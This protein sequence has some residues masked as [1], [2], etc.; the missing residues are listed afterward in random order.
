MDIPLTLTADELDAV[1][2]HIATLPDPKP[3]LTDYVITRTR[4]QVLV[5]LVE[6]QRRAQMDQVVAQQKPLLERLGRL[7]IDRQQAVQAVLE[8]QLTQ[9]ERGRP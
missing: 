3:A 1:Q 5:P 7:P 8:A 9:E 4:A 6:Q 2:R